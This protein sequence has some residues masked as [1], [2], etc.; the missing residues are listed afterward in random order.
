[1]H[2]QVEARFKDEV[3]VTLFWWPSAVLMC[4]EPSI[5]LR[6]KSL[7]SACSIAN[8]SLSHLLLL[9]HPLLPRKNKLVPFHQRLKGLVPSNVD[10]IQRGATRFDCSS[11][12]TL[13]S[14]EQN[15]VTVL[16]DVCHA[17]TIL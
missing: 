8:C 11:W 3:T 16:Q 4:A 2:E 9:V 15:Q 1:M 17:I 5:F 13:A 12:E 10:L 6:R 14:R 7:V